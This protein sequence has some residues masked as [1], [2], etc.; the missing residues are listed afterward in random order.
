[1]YLG[2]QRSFTCIDVFVR[3][4][5][6]FWDVLTDAAVCPKL[7]GGPEDLTLTVFGTTMQIQVR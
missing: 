6:S 7:L 4:P 5:L 2:P 3:C 1:M